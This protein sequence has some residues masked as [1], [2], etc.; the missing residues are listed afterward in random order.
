MSSTTQGKLSLLLRKETAERMTASGKLRRM[1]V[2]QMKM[3]MRITPLLEYTRVER[4][5]QIAGTRILVHFI[6]T[7]SFVII[8]MSNNMT[9]YVYKI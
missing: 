2:T 5:L 1:E 8:C 9:E 3:R 4:G 6:F 7:F